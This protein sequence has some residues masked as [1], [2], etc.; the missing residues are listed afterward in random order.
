MKLTKNQ[1][2]DGFNRLRACGPFDTAI[3]H[4]EVVEQLRAQGLID[5]KGG[6]LEYMGIKLI[7]Q[8]QKPVQQYSDNCSL[9]SKLTC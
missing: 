3:I 9:H 8:A 1:I 2:I 6:Q 7:I 5:E 4:P